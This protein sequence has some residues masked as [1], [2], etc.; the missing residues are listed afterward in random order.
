LA[1]R[2]GS[3]EVSVIGEKGVQE[4][5]G[6]ALILPWELQSSRSKGHLSGKYT[7]AENGGLASSVTRESVTWPGWSRTLRWSCRDKEA[8]DEGMVSALTQTWATGATPFLLWASTSSHAKHRVQTQNVSSS[9]KDGPKVN[10][11][12]WIYF[13]CFQ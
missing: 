10:K 6:E 11:Q 12:K 2:E 9:P 4:D 7:Q 1:W 8:S 13:C 3:A 5:G